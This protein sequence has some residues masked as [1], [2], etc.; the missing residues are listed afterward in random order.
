[1]SIPT[2]K[3]I[4]DFFGH[5]PSFCS[6]R[7]NI[8]L[9]K[10]KRNAHPSSAPCFNSITEILLLQ[11]LLGNWGGWFHW[12]WGC[13]EWMTMCECP[14][15]TNCLFKWKVIML[16]QQQLRLRFLG[17]FSMDNPSK[18]KAEVFLSLLRSSKSTNVKYPMQN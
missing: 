11:R 8:I 13:W 9:V 4:T 15:S 5:K 14:C 16:L 1:M 12:L 17:V 10:I 7:H 6:K 3:K 2:I 18:S